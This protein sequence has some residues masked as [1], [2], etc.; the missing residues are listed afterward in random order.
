MR[1]AHAR[2]R[3]CTR[4]HLSNLLLIY[5][6]GAQLIYIHTRGEFRWLFILPTRGGFHGFFSLN[7]VRRDPRRQ[8]IHVYTYIAMLVEISALIRK[9]MRR[10]CARKCC[11]PARR[12]RNSLIRVRARA[13]PAL[14]WWVYYF[15]GSFLQMILVILWIE[16]ALL[17]YT[18]LSVARLIQSHFLNSHRREMHNIVDAIVEERAHSFLFFPWRSRGEINADD[19]I[20]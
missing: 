3:W 1:L 2:T 14:S 13:R 19:F 17:K 5:D 11:M 18:K 15:S 9:S 8:R 6:S 4:A 12:E 10:W 7:Y 20:Y 16:F